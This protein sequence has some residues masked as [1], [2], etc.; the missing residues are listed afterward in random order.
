MTPL[1]T[2]PATLNPAD[3][4]RPLWARASLRRGLPG[5][6]KPSDAVSA[7]KRCPHT[8]RRLYLDRSH[9]FEQ[10]IRYVG[11]SHPGALVLRGSYI[12]PGPH[13]CIGGWQL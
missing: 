10:A 1:T 6:G 13:V 3:D 11:Q 2:D 12:N 9:D 7:R 8:L 4:D 5:D